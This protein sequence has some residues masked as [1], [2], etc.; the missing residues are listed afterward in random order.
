MPETFSDTRLNWFCVIRCGC[1]TTLLTLFTVNNTRPKHCPRQQSSPVDFSL[2]WATQSNLSLISFNP[3]I[4]KIKKLP[5]LPT[6]RFWAWSI[7]K[8]M[9]H[10]TLVSCVLGHD[11]AIL[12]SAFIIIWGHIFLRT[13]HH[14]SRHTISTQ[15]V[16]YAILWVQETG[17][18]ISSKTN[19]SLNLNQSRDK[20]KVY[21]IIE[22]TCS[23]N[24]PFSW[25]VK[26]EKSP[27]V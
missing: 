13:V 9:M 12:H 21:V 14:D 20:S 1:W 17:P 8:K 7:F 2:T 26:Q 10:L 18:W 15:R 24:L 4:K 27:Q 16:A 25:P 11:W 5:P 3:A 23:P 22:E 19:S 6:G